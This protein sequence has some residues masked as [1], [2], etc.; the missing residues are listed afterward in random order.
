M[1]VC[2]IFAGM[3]EDELELEFEELREQLVAMKA[4]GELRLRQGD[5]TARFLDDVRHG[6]RTRHPRHTGGAVDGG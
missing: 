2:A 3:K 1:M 6:L 4:G 5:A